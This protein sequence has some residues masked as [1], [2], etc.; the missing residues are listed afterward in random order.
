MNESTPSQSKDNLHEQ[1]LFTKIETVAQAQELAQQVMRTL[2]SSDESTK[3]SVAREVLDFLIAEEN[4]VKKNTTEHSE[5]IAR[6]FGEAAE[7][8]E[9]LIESFGPK[10]STRQ[11]IDKKIEEAQRYIESEQFI[12]AVPILYEA[13]NGKPYNSFW[14]KGENQEKRVELKALFEVTKGSLRAQQLSKKTK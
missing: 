14:K 8:V 2:E 11:R 7:I 13:L 3:L 5:E 4:R 10:E 6:V 9:L 12:H 1:I